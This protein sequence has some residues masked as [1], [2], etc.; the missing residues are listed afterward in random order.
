MFELLIVPL[1]TPDITSSITAMWN[2]ARTGAGTSRASSKATS[3]AMRDMPVLPRSGQIAPVSSLRQR[4]FSRDHA[5]VGPRLGQ[6]RATPTPSSTRVLAV[7]RIGRERRQLLR[8]EP[9]HVHRDRALARDAGDRLE[10]ALDA[11]QAAR[12]AA[13]RAHLAVTLGLAPARVRHGDDAGQH[14]GGGLDD[15]VDEV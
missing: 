1:F 3:T 7:R 10:V 13:E 12:R 5:R 8:P 14:V 4:I 11:D 6:R 2:A 15:A 9:A